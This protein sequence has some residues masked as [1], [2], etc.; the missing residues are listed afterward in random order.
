MKIKV[1]ENGNYP[2]GNFTVDKVKAIF[3]NIK[4]PIKAI[5]SHTSKWNDKEPVEVGTFNS[6]EVKEQDGKAIAYA[7]V[8]FNET[9]AKYHE[10]SILSLR[11]M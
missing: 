1:F 7:N 10:D 5:F 6:F 11:V 9:G 8:D 4:K 2:Q 3:G